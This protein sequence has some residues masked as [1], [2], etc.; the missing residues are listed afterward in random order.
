MGCGVS[1]AVAAQIEECKKADAACCAAQ[2]QPVFQPPVRRQ[3]VMTEAIAQKWLL[4]NAKKNGAKARMLCMGWAGSNSG[5]FKTWDLKD[6]EVIK[7]ELPARNA[8]FNEKQMTDVNL[9]AKKIAQALDVSGYLQSRIPLVIFGHSFGAMIGLH[10]AR[11]LKKDFNYVPKQLIFAGCRPL[12]R[13]GWPMNYYRENDDDM[14]QS[15]VDCGGMTKEM[16]KDKTLL[17]MVLPAIKMDHLAMDKYQFDPKAEKVEPPIL[18]MGGDV[19]PR[20]PPE[21]LPE[22]DR[23]TNNQLQVHVMPGGH[24][25]LKDKEGDFLSYLTKF[26][27]EAVTAAEQ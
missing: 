18:V 13:W 10:V 17:A 20:C 27:T 2:Q 15:L 21:Q 25:F 5:V 22:W 8:R 6:I 16:A 23:Y 7:V 1:K 14:V 24:F 12:H 3:S 19:D 9:M 4:P 11:V 26:V